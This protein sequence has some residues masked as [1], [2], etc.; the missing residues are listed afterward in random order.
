MGGGGAQRPVWRVC[1]EKKGKIRKFKYILASRK[2]ER[3]TQVP[4][5]RWRPVHCWTVGSTPPLS[6]RGDTG[7]PEVG[8]I[9][10]IGRYNVL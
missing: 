1:E 4:M 7:T 9:P 10:L 8:T 6:G 3:H 2:S 5:K